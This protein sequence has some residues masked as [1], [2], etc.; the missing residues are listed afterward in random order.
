MPLE[1]LCRK[2][3]KLCGVQEGGRKGVLRRWDGGGGVMRL[4][5]CAPAHIV[6]RIRNHPLQLIR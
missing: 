3:Q 1:C 5:T 2:A 4:G 6:P